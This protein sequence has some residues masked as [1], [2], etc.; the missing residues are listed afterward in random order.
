M[1]RIEVKGIAVRSGVSKNNH[2]FLPEELVKAVDRSIGKTYPL[3]K[4]HDARTD[5]TIGRITFGMANVDGSGDTIVTYHGF[6]IEDG[7]NILS[8]IQEGVITEVSIGAHAERMVKESED[9]I[10]EIPIGIHFAELSTTPTPAV[11]GTM[12]TKASIQNT[13]VKEAFTCK[14]CGKEFESKEQLT[15]HYEIHQNE[16]TE[17][18]KMTENKQE[19]SVKVDYAAELSRVQEELAIVKLE[20]AKKELDSAKKTIMENTPQPISTANVNSTRNAFEGY[21]VARDEDGMF[22]SKKLP[23]SL[24]F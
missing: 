12:L 24:R 5:N 16:K 21:I 4:D 14:E 8:K 3:I 17:E 11:D 13:I 6:A 10:E 23:T 20:Q 2:K 18:P 7:S 1:A 22:I 19:Q 9:S 15:K